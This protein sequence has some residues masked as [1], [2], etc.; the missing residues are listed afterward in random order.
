MADIV[1]GV[2]NPLPQGYEKKARKSQQPFDPA[3]DGNAKSAARLS[4]QDDD[5]EKR[6]DRVELSP[7]AMELLR[8]YREHHSQELSESS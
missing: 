5:P 4:A 3:V 8:R 2:D 7:E 6:R 1:K